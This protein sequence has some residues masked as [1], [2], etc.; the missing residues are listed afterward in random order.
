MIFIEEICPWFPEK[1]RINLQT[2]GKVRER[3]KGT[4][5]STHGPQNIP[6]DAWP[7]DSRDTL[8][9]RHESIKLGK[10]LEGTYSESQRKDETVP[11]APLIYE[12]SDKTGTMM[13]P[14][15]P[16]AKLNWRMS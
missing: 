15:I 2:W 10:K 6:M 9:P 14:L 13:S 8:D 11:S 7:L 5:H 16:E 12:V 3:V 4:T 1:G